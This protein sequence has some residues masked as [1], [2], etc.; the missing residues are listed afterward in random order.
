MIEISPECWQNTLFDPPVKKTN[1]GVT[2]GKRFL[3]RSFPDLFEACLARCATIFLVNHSHP[4]SLHPVS[5]LVSQQAMNLCKQINPSLIHFDDISLRTSLGIWRLREIPM[6]ASVHD[7]V[8][9]LGESNW[10]SKL[11]HRIAFPFI[12]LFLLHSQAMREMFLDVFNKVDAARVVVNK[13]A[14]Y[15]IYCRSG[16]QANADDGKTILFFGRLSPYK[17]IDVLIKAATI[18]ARSIRNLTVVI[19]G[20]PVPGYRLPKF[21]PLDNQGQFLVFKDY[22]TNPQLDALFR[23]ATV[24][25]CPYVDAS[26]S[27]VVLTAYGFSKPVVCSDTGG[28]REYVW[29]HRTGL[30]V[31]PNDYRCFAKAIITIMQ[32]PDLQDRMKHHLSTMMQ[33]QFNWNTVANQM[34]K[35]YS[36]LIGRSD[37]RQ[38]SETR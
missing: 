18:I 33:S 24:V 13:L 10:R 34:V 8:S 38:S 5:W 23:R 9:H 20:K 1:Y 21:P 29:P 17:G 11:A 26:Q 36:D 16:E 14:P 28:L 7:P 32:S 35:I 2:D 15:R 22:M 6:I 31:P 37:K 27:G 25:A 4:K 30:I 3:Q 19:A 12:S